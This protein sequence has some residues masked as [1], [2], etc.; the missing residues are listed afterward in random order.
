MP[1]LPEVEAWRRALD[2]DVSR[3]PVEQAGPAHIATLKTFDPPLAALAGERFAGA[4]R[5]AKRLL[6][7]TEDGEL[8]LMVHLM[9]AGRIRYLPAGAK[10]PKTPV[11]R[12]RFD[13]GGELVLT[14]AGRKKRAGVWLLRP[15]AVAAELAH[16]GP[17][18]D[19]LTAET[20]AP[21]LADNSRRLHS[22]LRDQRAIAGIGR[23]WA[24]EILNAARLSPYALSTQL[25]AEETEQLAAAI[26]SELGTRPRAAAGRRVE[27]GDVSRPRPP[28]PAV[29]ELPDA[30][31][32]GRF[33]GA[34]DLLL[35]DLPDG[36]P[37]AQGPADVEAPPMK[38]EQADEATEEL[39][40]AIH[41]LLPQLTEARTPPTLE[42]LDETVKGQTMLV[43]RNDED[44]EIIGTLT[45]I[46]YRV[47]SGLKGRIED[48]IV[49]NSARGKGVGEALTREGMARANEARVLML[50]LTSMPYRE[51]A[52]RLYKRLGFVRKPTNVYVWWPR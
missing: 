49:D 24:N 39:L 31:R 10:G 51:S 26:H 3:S 13:D 28:R 1:E 14:E 5:R 6:F 9:S 19:T 12:L 23:A 33:R 35:P 25:S 4:R 45:L 34:H 32:A 17:E 37:R 46:M 47:S 48:V 21:I 15:D 44:G 16:L 27:R 29:P 40:A 18:A 43:A 20:L 30:A 50:E 2:P 52:N 38:I 42:Q 22:L 11:F 36:R 41:R 7:P 8:T